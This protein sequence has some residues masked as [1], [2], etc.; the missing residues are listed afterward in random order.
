[1]ILVEPSP[2]DV[3]QHIHIQEFPTKGYHGDVLE[4]QIGLVSEGIVCVHLFDRDKILQ[5]NSEFAVL[6]ITGFYRYNVP[7]GQRNFRVLDAGTNANRAFV[8]VEKG[9]NTVAGAVAI[10][11]ALSL[12]HRLA[13]K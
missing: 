10:I 7:S 5:P 11:Q 8:D 3:R 13:A 12:V 4:S 1:V 9:A 2:L 6:V